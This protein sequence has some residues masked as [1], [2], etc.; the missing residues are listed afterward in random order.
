MVW[1]AMGFAFGGQMLGKPCEIVTT[2][3]GTGPAQ[4]TSRVAYTYDTEGRVATSQALTGPRF[5]SPGRRI[6]YAYEA[7]PD[8]PGQE[9]EAPMPG[10]RGCIAH[11]TD[12]YGPDDPT[13]VR[14]R[15]D[16]S[17][18]GR[19][20]VRR[21]ELD[22]YETVIS[23]LQVDADGRVVENGY[24]TR[25]VYDSRGRPTMVTNVDPAG[26]FADSPSGDFVR[27]PREYRT[28]YGY[29]SN[30]RVANFGFE[31]IVPSTLRLE[32]VELGT[33]EYGPDGML[34]AIRIEVRTA[35]GGNLSVTPVEAVRVYH[36]ETLW[37]TECGAVSP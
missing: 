28:S 15:I 27:V 5:E 4:M 23:T 9:V 6:V 19:V 35:G 3:R 36:R 12:Y 34:Q 10:V 31:D 24:G 32:R 17:L 37:R 20:E 13:G 22:G 33:Y 25:F 7:R 16:R 26:G 30:G 21:V 1:L 11:Y 8:C 2:E 14:H 29:D 18:R